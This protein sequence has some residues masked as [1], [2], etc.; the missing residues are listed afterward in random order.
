VID[1]DIGERVWAVRRF[2]RFYTRQI[3]VLQDQMRERP[4]SLAAL[5]VIYELAHRWT[6]SV[7]HAARR[8]YQATGY[9]LVREEPHDSWGHH[10]VAQTWEL[11]LQ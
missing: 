11:G 10:L 7:L 3:G 2:N 1:V 8:I 9:R 5:R 4:F 6:N